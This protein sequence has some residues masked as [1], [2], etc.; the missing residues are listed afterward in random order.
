MN[1][2]YHYKTPIGIVRMEECDEAVTAL[3]VEEEFDQEQDQETAL[4]KETSQ[5]LMEYFKKE[6]TTF[7]IPV[8]LEGTEFQK[9]VWEALLHIPYGTTQS[10]GEVAKQIQNPK[11]VRAIGGACNRNPVMI[12]VPC[13]RV[14][15]HNGSLVGFGAG[16][17]RKEYLL[18]LELQR[19]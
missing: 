8:K 4:L 18:N 15:G 5:Q 9:K 14:I 7:D 13:H 17:E 6:R 12:I 3:Y 19:K 11:A 1:Y 16:L 10:Y 2:C